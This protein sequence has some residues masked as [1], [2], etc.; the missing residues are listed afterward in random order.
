LI[1]F[2]YL[3]REIL[4]TMA[5]V[6]GVLLLVIM[7]NRF[8]RYFT[9]VAQGEFPPSLLGSLMLFHLPSFVQLILPL[10]FFLGIMLAYGQ[11]Y[12]NNE[13]TVLIACGTSPTRLLGTTFWP[14]ALVALLVGVCSLWLTPAGL[15]HNER[16]LAEQASHADFGSLISGRFQELNGLTVY[17]ESITRNNSL[18]RDVFI[19]DMSRDGARDQPTVTRSESGYQVNDDDGNRYLTLSNGA[20]YAVEPGN[21]S[22]ERVIFDTYAMLL[23]QKSQE[24]E[25]DDTELLTTPALLASGT[26]EAMAAFQ[27]RLSLVLMVPII[28]LI[29][30]PLSRANP[31]QGRFAKLLPAIFLYISYMSLLLAAQDAVGGGRLPVEVGVW[32]IHVGF[33]LIGVWLMRRGGVLGGRR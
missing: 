13:M 11:L 10:A 17:A 9:D 23:Q 15:A 4:T 18:M 24:V 2:R 28:T 1:V 8:I 33:G 19:A 16:V 21:A 12:L 14:S 6:A 29:A 3:T 31:R 25:Y 27:W 7:G 30:L 26:P 20:H 32:P 22:A 5:A